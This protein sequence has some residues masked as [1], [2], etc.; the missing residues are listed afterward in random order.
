MFESE[1]S[2]KKVENVTNHL[3]MNVGGYAWKQAIM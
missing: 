3:L 1:E 2:R